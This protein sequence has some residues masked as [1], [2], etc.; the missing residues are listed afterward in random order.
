MYDFLLKVYP[1]TPRIQ[2]SLFSRMLVTKFF[3]LK[4]LAL[5]ALLLWKKKSFKEGL[6]FGA[7]FKYS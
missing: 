6:L 3:M 7:M 4:C 1:Q 5:Q 2:D